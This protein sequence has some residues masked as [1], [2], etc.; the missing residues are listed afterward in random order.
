MW[1][2]PE[3][4]EWKS[5][6][7]AWHGGTGQKWRPNRRLDTSDIPTQWFDRPICYVPL[8][9]VLTDN[10]NGGPPGEEVVDIFELLGDGE[11]WLHHV[12]EQ[13]CGHDGA[14]VDLEIGGW[15]LFFQEKITNHRVVG[16][17]IVVESD[18]VKSPTAGLPPDVLLNNL[19]TMHQWKKWQKNR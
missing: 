2:S 7:A 8:F 6:L 4:P 18:L 13:G 15:S 17:P 10:S 14:A 12:Q 9:R 3:K 11:L 19:D 16:L 1:D 5:D